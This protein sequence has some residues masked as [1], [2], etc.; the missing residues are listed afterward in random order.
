MQPQRT[1]ML[2]DDSA[3]IRKLVEI[4]LR[5]EGYLVE[6]FPDGVAAMAALQQPGAHLPGLLILD[7]ELPK[8]NGY[9]IARYLRSKSA[10]QTVP[11]MMIS[12]H[13]GVVERL[14]SRLAGAKVYLAKPFTTQMLLQAIREAQT[15]PGDIS[16]Q[17][18]SQRLLY[19]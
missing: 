5:R 2:I 17:Q 4:T 12:R 14:K 7:I 1:I 9:E 15:K 19:G 11:I 8:M 10:W 3:T 13:K 16:H 18:A 6:S